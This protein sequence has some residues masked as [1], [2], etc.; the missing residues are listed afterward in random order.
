ML[1]IHS[2]PRLGVELLDLHEIYHP[3]DP[4]KGWDYDKVF[5]DDISYHEEHGEAYKNYG[6]NKDRGCVVIARPD[7]H[8]GW[9]GALEDVHDMHRNFSEI[10]ISRI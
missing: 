4:E 8:V 3:Y 2:A 1:T 9:I 7:Q 6:V 10:L 5:V